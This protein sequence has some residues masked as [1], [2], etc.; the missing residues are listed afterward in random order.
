[1]K[2]RTLLALSGCTLLALAACSSE[3]GRPDPPE[4]YFATH[5]EAD[6][7]RKFQYTV[8]PPDQGRPR[9]G[10]GRPGNTAGHVSG[11]SSRGVAGGVTAGTGGGGRQTS[12]SGA[13][14]YDRFQQINRQL[15]DM[16]EQE[17][18][19]SGFCQQGYR[20]TERVVEPA[21]IYIRGECKKAVDN[22]PTP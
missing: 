20:E 5:I 15:E 19:N 7:T 17:L 22:P 1:M 21:T 9:A 18:K 4:G 6:G 13:S 2:T 12:S 16:L 11:S 10:S 3:P 8:V 14:A